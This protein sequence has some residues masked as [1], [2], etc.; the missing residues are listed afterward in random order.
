MRVLAIS[1]RP[2]RLGG[3]VFFAGAMSLRSQPCSMKRHVLAQPGRARVRATSTSTSTSTSH[4]YEYEYE[5]E[6]EYEPR[7][8]GDLREVRRG[9][10]L[11]GG[12]TRPAPHPP[13]PPSRA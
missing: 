12:R 10:P 5:H 4:E 2:W 7:D 9:G 6:H 1:W 3:L 8:S 13:G 11:T